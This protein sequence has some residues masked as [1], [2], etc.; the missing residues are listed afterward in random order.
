MDTVKNVDGRCV[1]IS[2][3]NA[4]M[5]FKVDE[6]VAVMHHNKRAGFKAH[7][8]IVIS[9]INIAHLWQ[10]V[11]DKRNKLTENR[12][13]T[14]LLES[15]IA[16]RAELVKCSDFTVFLVCTLVDSFDCKTGL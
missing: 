2:A 9:D 12:Y 11:D 10:I 3:Y 1:F 8:R 13:L 14:G 16:C 4:C 15:Q 6:L 5:W 7:K